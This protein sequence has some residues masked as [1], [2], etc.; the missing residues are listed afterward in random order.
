M[1]KVPKII[2]RIHLKW[3]FTRG[4]YKNRMFTK[5]AL[6]L[7]KVCIPDKSLN[8][9]ISEWKELGSPLEILKDRFG[10]E[11]LSVLYANMLW[12]MG[13]GMKDTAVLHITHEDDPLFEQAAKLFWDV[14]LFYLI[15][16]DYQKAL[17]RL[18][19]MED[20]GKLPKAVCFVDSTV[21]KRWMRR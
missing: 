15:P 3:L 6:K 1:S 7:K 12:Q 10:R 19:V 2:K 17:A 8:R 9:L 20:R 5:I 21:S 13:P 18:H 16:G 11:M 14:G 4:T